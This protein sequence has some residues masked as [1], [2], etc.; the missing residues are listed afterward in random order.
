METGVGVKP[1]GAHIG[2]AGV[3]GAS[4]RLDAEFSAVRQDKGTPSRGHRELVLVKSHRVPT[5]AP[6]HH[7][8][9]AANSIM[10]HHLLLRVM[11]ITMLHH[12]LHRVAGSMLLS[13]VAPA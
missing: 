8:I 5:I 6:H 3:V 11:D 1:T 12:L 7:G 2:I 13:T 10:R 4:S 9:W